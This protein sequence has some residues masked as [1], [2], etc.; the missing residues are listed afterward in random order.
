MFD[1][2][3]AGERLARRASAAA[4]HLQHRRLQEQRSRRRML[5]RQL[6]GRLGDERDLGVAGGRWPRRHSRRGR[7]ATGQEQRH[8]LLV[9]PALALHRPDHLRVAGGA[10]RRSVLAR[11]PARGLRG[12]RLFARQPNPFNLY[13]P[14][15][16]LPRIGQRG[17]AL[18][19]SGDAR[20]RLAAQKR[21]QLGPEIER[22]I[23]LPALPLGERRERRLR[24]PEIAAPD[25]RPGRGEQLVARN[26]RGHRGAHPA[27]RRA[28]RP[29]RR[30][31]A[32]CQQK[33]CARR[34]QS[35]HSIPPR[36]SAGS[37]P[38]TETV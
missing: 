11:E 31:G 26:R 24:G 3:E 15:Q 7:P 35:P 4:R 17:L 14:P 22:R 1:G 5:G 36:L 18:F 10:R 28:A 19:E 21:E 6:A 9:A 32:G 37:V 16:P 30:S 13:Q 8:R 12:L 29:A 2:V 25:R 27:G 20:E 23:G 33:R 38:Q 34:A